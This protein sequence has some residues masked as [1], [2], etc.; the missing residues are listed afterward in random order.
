MLLACSIPIAQYR[1]RPRSRSLAPWQ[2]I[3]KCQHPRST[4]DLTFQTIAGPQACVDA[5]FCSVGRRRQSITA[6]AAIYP[7][8]PGLHTSTHKHF[9]YSN[10]SVPPTMDPKCHNIKCVLFLTLRI[11]KPNP[12]F[13]VNQL[14][15]IHSE[16]T[17]CSYPKSRP[18][19]PANQL[20]RLPDHSPVPLRS[21]WVCLFFVSAC[22]Q[23]LLQYVYTCL[24]AAG[25]PDHPNSL[26]LLAATQSADT[27]SHAHRGE[28][29]PVCAFFRL[30][31]NV[32]VCACVSSQ[33]RIFFVM[34]FAKPRMKHQSLPDW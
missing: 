12:D 30:H 34:W 25:S 4:K 31:V 9:W 32:C 3:L 17:C 27:P 28:T 19:D 10:K 14:K 13:V 2:Q 26:S 23:A 15:G 11:L 16:H 6:A 22:T 18:S 5:A 24:S 20:L 7:S 29:P 21:C 33:I 8:E 1:M